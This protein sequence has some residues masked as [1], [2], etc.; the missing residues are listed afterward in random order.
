MTY[1]KLPYYDYLTTIMLLL[2]SFWL[3][4]HVYFNWDASW[5]IEAAKRI[6]NGN[7]SYSKNL[8]DDNLPMVFWYFV[9]AVLLNHLTGIWVLT[10]S[11]ASVLL[12]ILL[13]VVL[14]DIYFRA[15]DTQWVSKAIRYALLISLLFFGSKE[16]AQRDMVV[17]T[18]VFP[19]IVLMTMQMTSITQERALPILIG[20]LTAI[21][22]AMNP[23]YGLI[24]LALETQLFLHTRK[25]TIYRPELITLVVSYCIYLCMIMVIYPDYFSEIIPSY[26]TFSPAV[27][28]PLHDLLIQPQSMLVYYAA[29]ILFV[30]RLNKIHHPLLST[31]WISILACFLVFLI[32]GKLFAGHVVFL[33]ICLTLFFVVAL[34]QT[35]KLAKNASNYLIFIIPTLIP[36]GYLSVFSYAQYTEDYDYHHN[37][38]T[39]IH[40]LMTYFNHQKSNST[41]LSLAPQEI[42]TLPMVLYTSL[43]NVTP[44]ADCWPLEALTQSDREQM[45]LP[46]W[47]KQRIQQ[48]ATILPDRIG[49]VLQTDKPDFILVNTKKNQSYFNNQPFNLIHFYEHSVLFQKNWR[50]YHL[51]KTI[52][53]YEIYKRITL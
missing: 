21:G 20:L 37:T 23:F 45:M 32:N 9:P 34:C 16:F 7:A 26:L 15:M 38:R 6:V 24:V 33:T 53:H 11:I 50:H 43:Q 48:Y 18:F 1:Q 30:F 31:L 19:Y 42:P 47:K 14:S 51:M 36:L 5:H 17:T 44:W 4:H 49:H 3:Q 13:C 10:L 27:N 12:S 28:A 25:I 52:S 41:L 2:F 39:S 46:Q 40:R 8:F 35:I 22:L 29:L